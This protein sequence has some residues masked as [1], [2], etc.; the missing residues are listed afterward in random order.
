MS[1]F[2]CDLHIHSCLSPCG[3]EEMTPGSIAGMAR[4]NG[5]DIAALTD[6]NACG[7][8]EPF[9][10]ACVRYGVVPV[11]GMELTTSEDVH[12]LCLFRTLAD[13]QAFAA[14]VEKKRVK[15]KN[16]PEFFGRQ[17]LIGPDDEPAGEEEFLL[18]NATRLSLEDAAGLARSYRGAALPAHIDREANGILAV[19]GELPEK[20][21]F[22]VVEIRHPEKTAGLE[23]EHPALRGKRSVISSDAHQLWRILDPGFAIELP[24]SP[25]AEDQTVRDAL[26][27]YLDGAKSGEQA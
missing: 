27:D 1:E 11:A 19:L 2:L 21:D 23:R 3:D 17:I 13:A 14:A 25:D 10:A 15:V 8:C 7:N 9:F 26:I 22:P 4:L 18:V 12:M 24:C 16:R 5:L 20:P 6:H